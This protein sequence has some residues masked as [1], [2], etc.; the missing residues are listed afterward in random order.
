MLYFLRVLKHAHGWNGVNWYCLMF[1]WRRHLPRHSDTFLKYEA[2]V[3]YNFH[4]LMVAKR[5]AVLIG[6]ADFSF[7]AAL[8]EQITVR[9]EKVASSIDEE[10]RV[11]SMLSI[12]ISITLIFSANINENIRSILRAWYDIMMIRLFTDGITIQLH[13]AANICYLGENRDASRWLH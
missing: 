5:Y 8:R 11:I 7:I 9:G 6:H 13:Q 2:F 10:R 4:R 12:N 3:R 1:S